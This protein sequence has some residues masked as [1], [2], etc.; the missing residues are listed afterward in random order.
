MC[1]YSNERQ[2]RMNSMK[3]KNPKKKKLERM[4]WRPG[5]TGVPWGH[6]PQSAVG[7]H[8]SQGT[9]NGGESW[10]ICVSCLPCQQ[11]TPLCFTTPPPT[12]THTHTH[13]HTRTVNTRA[14]TLRPTPPHQ[15]KKVEKVTHAAKPNRGE[16]ERGGERSEKGKYREADRKRNES[17]RQVCKEQRKTLK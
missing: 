2:K 9:A 17:E 10:E 5:A 7:Q 14:P 15:L 3:K 6:Q 16:H 1:Q 12:H 4:D 13:T 11:T 8:D